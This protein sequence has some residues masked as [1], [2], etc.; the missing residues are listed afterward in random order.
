MSNLSWFYALPQPVQAM[1]SGAGGDFLGG[2]AAEITLRLISKIG[3]PIRKRFQQEHK[4][5]ALNQATAKAL[6]LTVRYF[7][8]DSD[9]M[10]HYLDLFGQWTEREAVDRE[11]GK[12]IAPRSNTKFNMQVLKNEFKAQGFDVI[13]LG[14]DFSEFVHRFASEFIDAIDEK[15]EL[16]GLINTKLSRRIVEQLD[17]LIYSSKRAADAGERAAD[18]TELIARK[19]TETDKLDSALLRQEYLASVRGRYRSL[20]LSG[21]PPRPSLLSELHKSSLVDVYVE[22]Q[23]TSG[24]E[25]LTEFERYEATPLPLEPIGTGGN[26]DEWVYMPRS[27]TAEVKGLGQFQQPTLGEQFLSEQAR[28]T[29]SVNETT[30]TG[31]MNLWD[32]LAQHQRVILL[33]SMGA[34]KTTTI[35][36]LALALSGETEVDSRFAEKSLLPIIIRLGKFG[37][38]IKK[39]PGYR[40]VDHLYAQFDRDDFGEFLKRELK[41]GHCLVVMDGLDEAPNLAEVVDRISEFVA[42]HPNNQIVITS[43]PNASWQGLLGVGFEPVSMKRLELEQVQRFFTR[44]CRDLDFEDFSTELKKQPRLQA[45][46]SSPVWL[47]LLMRMYRYSGSLPKSLIE[48]LETA[49]DMQI[50]YWPLVQQRFERTEFD[51]ATIRKILMPVA[52]Q[53]IRNG[54]FIGEDEIIKTFTNEFI[55]TEGWKKARARRQSKKWV[56]LLVDEVGILL[57]SGTDNLGNRVFE[58]VHAV[59]A[60]YLAACYL[61]H[62]W[63]SD[64]QNL[65]LKHVHLVHR[66][67]QWDSIIPLFIAHLGLPVRSKRTTEALQVILALDSKWEKVVWRD[68]LLAGQCLGEAILVEGIHKDI[69]SKLV[70]LLTDQNSTLR[71]SVL[72]TLEGLRGTKY[73]KVAIDEI[74]RKLKERCPWYVELTFAEALVNLGESK[75]SRELLM[76]L[77]EIPL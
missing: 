69:I 6:A 12:L 24:A 39:D 38:R 71:R 35:R 57:S 10:T 50:E 44:Y 41:L 34:G 76:S 13:N 51:S 56:D 11:I 73:A 14:I 74:Q 46:I 9:L 62:L 42:G 21:Y 75:Q 68:Q 58:F 16:R 63:D 29:Q 33:G 65:V 20:D 67:F 1:L 72:D 32:A 49:L 15:E 17:E 64:E 30:L 54:T 23:L 52:Y 28:K 2:L 61:S 19:L 43:R 77:R 7:T 25:S 31:T 26:Q 66:S 4:R 18:A 45:I 3:L 40:L 22:L 36:Y 60:H 5:V 8:D 47:T 27:R 70:N 55:V 59:F 37:R 53:T 48:V